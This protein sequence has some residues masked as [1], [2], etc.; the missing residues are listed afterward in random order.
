MCTNQADNTI[1]C[2]SQQEHGIYVGF[3]PLHSASSSN[4][5]KHDAFSSFSKGGLEILQNRNQATDL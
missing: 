2:T 5:Q 4:R 1:A 3:Y